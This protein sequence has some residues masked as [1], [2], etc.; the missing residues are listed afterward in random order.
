[1]LKN[2]L[3]IAVRNLVRRKTFSLINIL[4][5]AFGIAACL[6]IYMYVSYE[7]SYDTFNVNADNIYRLKNVRYYTSGTDSSAGCTAR[8]GPALKE[9]IPEVVDFTR[10]RKISALVSL[11]NQYFNKENILWADS[12]LFTMFSFPL[13]SGNANKVLAEKYSAVITREISMLLERP[14]TLAIQTLELRV[15]P[16]ISLPTHTYILIFFF[17]LILS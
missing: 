1:M 2:Y 13:I 16:K 8:L 12:S 9:E 15:L 11:N 5:L 14:F 4:G 6:I 3:K 7:K 10:L 17:L